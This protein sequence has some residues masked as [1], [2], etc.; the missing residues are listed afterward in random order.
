MSKFRLSNTL[1][2]IKAPESSLPGVFLFVLR[3]AQRR[4]WTTAGAMHL[5]P[6]ENSL[7]SAKS[8]F[9][10]F[11]I[12]DNPKSALNLIVLFYIGLI[13]FFSHPQDRFGAGALHLPLSKR[14]AWSYEVRN[15]PL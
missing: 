1:L 8:N 13:I 3:T 10:P 12:R 14:G 7:C 9:P 15:F 5:H 2:K 4:R 6:P 11:G